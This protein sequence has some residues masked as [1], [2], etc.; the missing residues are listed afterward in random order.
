MSNCLMYVA[1]FFLLCLV[2]AFMFPLAIILI[3]SWGL[4][5]MAALFL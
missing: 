4:L 1:V 2:V 3:A 5:L